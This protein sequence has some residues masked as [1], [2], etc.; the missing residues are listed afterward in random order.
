LVDIYQDDN[1]FSFPIGDWRSAERPMMRTTEGQVVDTVRYQSQYE[2]VLGSHG[3]SGFQFEA[4]EAVYGPVGS[5]GYPKPLWNKLTGTIDHEVAA[6]MRD[7]GYD[8][9]YYAQSNWPVLGPK[10]VGKINIFSGEMDD[11]FLNLAVYRFQDFLK[12]TE[13]PH[14]EGRFEYGRPMKGHNWHMTNWADMLREM[15]DYVKK[16]TPA[17]EEDPSLWNY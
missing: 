16:N 6:Y 2:E 13:N 9:Q 17:G 1:A 7:H 12:T 8:L 15:A 4:W 11:Y 10:L 5:D 3:R 14:Y